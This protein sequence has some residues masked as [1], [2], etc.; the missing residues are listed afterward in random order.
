MDHQQLLDDVTLVAQSKK[1]TDLWRSAIKVNAWS[2]RAPSSRNY[3]D[4]AL[5]AACFVDPALAA[6]VIVDRL[7]REHGAVDSDLD[8][9]RFDAYEFNSPIY[10]GWSAGALLVAWARFDAHGEDGEEAKT[11]LRRHLRARTV[12][13]T[14]CSLRHVEQGGRRYRG[15]GGYPAGLRGKPYY[16]DRNGN[17]RLD[18]GE[19]VNEFNQANPTYATILGLDFHWGWR[20]YPPTARL[21]GA[22]GL[23]DASEQERLRRV[24]ACELEEDDRAWIAT[25]LAFVR[26]VGDYEIHKTKDRVVTFLDGPVPIHHTAPLWFSDVSAEQ[27]PVSA[28]PYSKTRVRQT[29]SSRWRSEVRPD[30]G[31][32][33][34]SGYALGE[35]RDG[36]RVRTARYEWPEEPCLRVRLSVDV[37]P[38]VE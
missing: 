26:L 16:L 31:R 10:H 18:D 6:R 24:L 3:F 5:A 34:E 23:F 20:R 14:L 27:A 13:W 32:R 4:M 38:R 8:L 1:P 15:P 17:Q 29:R 12:L 21:V 2:R 35:F 36:Q 19:Q 33:T 28:W 11:I 22:A 9:F 30:Q 7:A 37:P 25:E